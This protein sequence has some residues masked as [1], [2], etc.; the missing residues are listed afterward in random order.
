MRHPRFVLL[1]LGQFG[2]QA[3]PLIHEF[4][5]FYVVV[6]VVERFLYFISASATL[7]SKISS[8]VIFAYQSC[9]DAEQA[10]NGLRY[11]RVG[12]RGFALG[13]GKLEARK[14]LVNRAESHTSGARFV[15][16]LFAD[17]ETNSKKNW[18]G[19]IDDDV[20]AH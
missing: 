7:P 9:K 6:A 15:S 13:A 10:A 17:E 4:D 14:M 3:I 12:G 11:L 1:A 5:S 8:G 19:Q 20:H 2:A 18:C 16:R